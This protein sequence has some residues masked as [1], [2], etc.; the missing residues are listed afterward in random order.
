[1]QTVACAFCFTAFKL[2]IRIDNSNAMIEMTNRSSI[3]VNPFLLS[4]FLTEW[5]VTKLFSEVKVITTA[6]FLEICT[7]LLGKSLA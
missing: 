7:N 3:K 1:M 5:I 6:A 2:G 4:V